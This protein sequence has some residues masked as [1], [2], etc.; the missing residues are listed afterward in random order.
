MPGDWFTTQKELNT[1]RT[2]IKR[3]RRI[4]PALDPFNRLNPLNPCPIRV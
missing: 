2:R 3:I 4:E 1:D